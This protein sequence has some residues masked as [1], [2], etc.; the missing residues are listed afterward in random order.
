MKLCVKRIR[1]L[2][3]L[4]LEEKKRQKFE[5]SI[6]SKSQYFLSVSSFFLLV[7]FF[8][9]PK[10]NI[11]AS[12]ANLASGHNI[13]RPSSILVDVENRLNRK[14]RISNRF[15]NWPTDGDLSLIKPFFPSFN[16]TKNFVV[17][18][19][20]PSVENEQFDHYL[21]SGSQKC[22]VRHR[23]VNFY[24]IS[25]QNLEDQGQVHFLTLPMIRLVKT[26]F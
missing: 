10:T 17:R 20:P 15:Q 26:G 22:N 16:K 7:F 19:N 11:F 5:K 8:H 3:S 23:V 14:K 24:F 4:S 13:S 1:F 6:Y 2:V 9:P 18:L 25:F 21:K 12:F